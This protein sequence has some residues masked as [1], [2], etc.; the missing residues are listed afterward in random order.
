MSTIRSSVLTTG[1]E[2]Y[3]EI[4]SNDRT[5]PRSSMSTLILMLA[6]PIISVSSVNVSDTRDTA[7]M[8]L[9][10][11]IATQPVTHRRVRKPPPGR[12]N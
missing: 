10:S 4:A 9:E 2:K 7:E 1:L 12:M 6:F 8:L 5:S 11:S 3:F